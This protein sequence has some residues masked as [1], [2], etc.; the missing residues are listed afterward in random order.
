MTRLLALVILTGIAIEAAR[1]NRS[2]RRAFSGW[3]W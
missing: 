1:L 3:A 2:L